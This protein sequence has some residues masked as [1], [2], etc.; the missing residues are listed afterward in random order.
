MSSDQMNRVILIAEDEAKKLKD[1][2][3]IKHLSMGMSQDYKLA[4]LSGSTM[5]RIG[6]MLFT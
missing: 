6:R 5:V 3:N 2:Y 4:V 1:E